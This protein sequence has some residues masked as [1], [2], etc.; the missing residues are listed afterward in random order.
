MN[1]FFFQ[2]PFDCTLLKDL[3][4]LPNLRAFKLCCSQLD[5][6][7]Q[8][9]QLHHITKF[10]L[11]VRVGDCHLVRLTEIFPSL[12]SLNVAA[13][14]E[15]WSADVEGQVVEKMPH[16]CQVKLRKLSNFV[17]DGDRDDGSEPGFA[18]AGFSYF[19]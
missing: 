4:S 15:Y 5:G 14:E 6:M 8:N 3:G 7:N 9:F 17:T 16:S 13:R 11:T 1:R 2:N 12:T 10:D 18:N 19:E